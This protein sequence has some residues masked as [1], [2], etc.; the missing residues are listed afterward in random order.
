MSSA[1]ES[2][3][4]PQ[5]RGSA[6]AAFFEALSLILIMALALIGNFTTIFTILRV[7]S[8]RQNL[9]N[10]F[11]VNLCIMDLVVCFFSMSFSLADLFHEGYLLSYGGFCRVSYN[12]MYRQILSFF[13]T[14]N[15]Q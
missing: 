9:H 4:D 10:A 8:L 12:N 11:V 7:R 3:T 6:V 5:H 1:Y 14:L 13:G 15:I 2:G